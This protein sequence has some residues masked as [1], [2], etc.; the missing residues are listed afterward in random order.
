MPDHILKV[1]HL[2]K[3]FPGRDH[4]GNRI[5]TNIISDISFT[6]KRGEIVGIVGQSGCGKSTL[7]KLIL[8]LTKADSGQVLYENNDIY[9]MK[10]SQFRKLRPEMQLIFQ[11]SYDCMNPKMTIQKLLLEG[12]L[13]HKIYEN[14]WKALK[15]IGNILTECGMDPDCL[16]RYPQELS[17]GQ[18]QR[19]AIARVLLLQPRFIIGDEVVSAL[20]VPTQEQILELFLDLRRKLGLSIL[21]ISHDLAVIRRICDRIIVME[22]G[23]IVEM[24]KTADVFKDPQHS[25]TRKLISS[26]LDFSYS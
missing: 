10:E 12:M 17:G 3:S 26:V 6:I 5:S 8:R 19:I 18:L 1:Q 24:G 9:R 25:C 2:S 23:R 13:E 20:D 15:A 11:N 7:A 14:K 22:Q 21:F 4:S 16:I